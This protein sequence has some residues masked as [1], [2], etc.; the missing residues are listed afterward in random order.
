MARPSGPWPE[1]SGEAV[2]RRA[3]RAPLSLDEFATQA[4]LLGLVNLAATDTLARGRSAS[5]T[6]TV[7]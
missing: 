3:A 2:P 5:T 1:G 4:P 6:V 7:D